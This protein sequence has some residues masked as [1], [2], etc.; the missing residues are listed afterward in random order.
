MNLQNLNVQTKIYLSFAIILIVILIM[1]LLS[2]RALGLIGNQF[3]RVAQDDLPL[4]QTISS[5]GENKMALD[6]YF[7]LLLSPELDP[8]ERR[9][10]IERKNG[11]IDEIAELIDSL[12]SQDISAQSRQFVDDIATEIETYKSQGRVIDGL[13]QDIAENDIA[14]PF[15]LARELESFR[16][17]HLAAEVRTLKGVYQ[18]DAFEFVESTECAFGQW[19]DSFQTTNPQLQQYLTQARADH[20]EFHRAMGDVSQEVG[21]GNREQAFSIF[22]GRMEPAANSVISTLSEMSQTAIEAN[23]PF[24]QST[25]IVLGQLVPLSSTIENLLNELKNNIG[26]EV[27][28]SV[29]QGRSVQSAATRNQITAIVI[30]FILA[31]VLGIILARKFRADLSECGRVAGAVSSGD[32]TV[33][34]DPRLLAQKDEFGQLAVTFE[35]MRTHLVDIARSLIAGSDNMSG[36]SGQV[37]ASA[38]QLSQGASEQAAS[39][40]ETSA[41]AEEMSASIQQNAENAQVTSTIAEKVVNQA[42]EGEKSVTATVQAMREIADKIKIIDDIAY[43]TNLLALNAAIEAARAGDHGKGF[44]VVAEEVRKLA[45]RSQQSSQDI[46]NVA[47]QSVKKA[48]QAGTTIT[49]IL[50]EIEKTSSLIAEIEAASAEQDNGARQISGAMQQLST[51]T[52]QSASASEE[53]AA[54]A[55]QMAA[56][57]KE[58]QQIAGFFKI[59]K[60]SAS[61]GAAF[62]EPQR[63]QPEQL[64]QPIES[65]VPLQASAADDDAGFVRF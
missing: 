15:Q 52:Q 62:R 29:D 38:Q 42:N 26:I 43:K 5:L 35:G 48:E 8:A 7:R 6:G 53:L 39:V 61:S 30:G 49:A 46:G 33:S 13:Q 57:S 65:T 47:V 20:D 17:D 28:G 59:E 11:R 37:S 60:Q 21:S 41:S 64:S 22:S 58:L 12:E 16:G 14:N 18:L 51:V 9:R 54:T 25:E 4:V 55:E 24:A 19:L 63:S 34:A 10:I 32:L 36:A 44:A 3:E 45:E 56:Q 40:E 1:G 2:L 27:A 31:S 23:A 50:P